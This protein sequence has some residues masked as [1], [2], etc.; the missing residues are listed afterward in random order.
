MIKKLVWYLNE[1]AKSIGMIGLWIGV[2]SVVVLFIYGGMST[3]AERQ[4]APITRKVADLDFG[5][6]VAVQDG[7]TTCYVAFRLE[8][9]GNHPVGVSC[10]VTGK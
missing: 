8:G 10:V 2:L 9:F 5:T 1:N 6:L 4:P 3:A 7:D